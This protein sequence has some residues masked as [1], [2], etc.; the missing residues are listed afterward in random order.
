[1]SALWLLVVPV[2]GFA[3]YVFGAVLRAVPK[4]NEDFVFC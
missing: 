3:W 4:C 1:M 2:A